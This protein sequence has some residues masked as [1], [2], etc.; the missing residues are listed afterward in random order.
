[1]SVDVEG[2]DLAVLESNDWG[3]FRPVVVLVEDLEV[4]GI[5]GAARSPVAEYM[6]GRGYVPFARTRLTSLFIEADK[7]VSTAVGVCLREE[8]ELSRQPAGAAS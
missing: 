6:T 8:R 1:M 2:M 7:A 4:R 3:R 5:D